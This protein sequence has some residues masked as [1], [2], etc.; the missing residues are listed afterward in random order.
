MNSGA[1][2]RW[3]VRD[4]IAGQPRQ[5]WLFDERTAV[6]DGVTNPQSSP[7][8][9]FEAKDGESIWDAIRRNSNWLDDNVTEG[10]FHLMACG[11]GELYP[12]IARPHA[13][14]LRDDLWYPWPQLNEAYVAESKTQLIVLARRLEAICQ[15]V[16]PTQV[17]LDV[18]GHEIRN[19]LIIA[20]TEFEMH[21]RGV[22]KR[23]GYTDNLNINA[24]SR[25]ATPMR[26]EEYT[27]KFRA[28][29]ALPPVAPFAGWLHTPPSGSLPWY[30]AYNGVKHNREE[31]FE[32]GKLR[33]AFEAVSACI[34]LF[35]A[36][37]GPSAMAAE[38]ST[39]VRLDLPR[40]PISDMYLGPADTGWS[41][42]NCPGI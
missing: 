41:L 2:K 23:N 39:F 7:G 22:L 33:H 32:R 17:T 11:P 40:W 26:L 8:S 42:V 4:R 9:Y 16:Q 21:C 28:F 6:R 34:V 35:V 20:A 25:L 13:L 31:E 37:F 10:L 27:V 38:L 15:T 12:R 3:Y 29:P 24:Y 30:A 36:Q 19:L 14:G 1:G 18:F 5:K